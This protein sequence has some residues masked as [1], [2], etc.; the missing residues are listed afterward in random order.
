MQFSTQNEVELV[1]SGWEQ[2]FEAAGK[3]VLPTYLMVYWPCNFRPIEMEIQKIFSF[4]SRSIFS[5]MC[6]YIY[7]IQ[8]E[9]YIAASLF[10]L[11]QSSFT[12][13]CLI[14]KFEILPIYHNKIHTFVMNKIVENCKLLTSI[15]LN[16]IACL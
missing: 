6:N 1:Y 5:Q 11:R 9:V 13:L 2:S 12:N 16:T 7:L 4:L 15:V 8:L 10:K 3:I 14:L